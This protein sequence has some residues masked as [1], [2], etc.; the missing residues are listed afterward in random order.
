MIASFISQNTKQPSV[1]C[2]QKSFAFLGIAS[3]ILVNY[4]NQMLYLSTKSTAQT[5]QTA[6]Q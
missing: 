5:T 1:L 6:K 2:A 4:L 3:D